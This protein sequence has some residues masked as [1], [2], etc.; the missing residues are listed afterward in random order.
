MN[1]GLEVLEATHLFGI[2][3]ESIDI[4]I[5]PQS[6]VHSMV[7]FNDGST[8]AQLGIPD[9]KGAIAYAMSHPDRYPIGQPLPDFPRMGDLTFDAPDFDKFPCLSL[10]YEASRVGGTLPAVLNAANEVAVH[11][12][13]KRHL[14]FDGIPRTIQQVMAQHSPISNPALEDILEADGWARKKAAEKVQATGTSYDQ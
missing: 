12:F 2:S 4:L 13:L 8:L 11:A 9:M 7:S 14:S 3:E 1:K 5:H 10:A 6:I